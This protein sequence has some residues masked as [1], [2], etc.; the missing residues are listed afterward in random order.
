MTDDTAKSADPSRSLPATDSR[1]ELTHL[2][3]DAN[4]LARLGYRQE[5]QRRMSRFSNFAVSFSLICILAGGITAFPTAL[6]AGGG[7]S[8]AGGWLIGTIFAGLVALSMAQIASAYPT[9][10]GLYHWSSMLGNRGL[11]W[12]TAWFNLI[13]LVLAF[14]S[15]N[16]GLYDPFIKTLLVPLLGIDSFGWGLAH[17]MGWIVLMTLSQVLLNHYA[18]GLTT[19]FI[20]LSGYLILAVAIALVVLLW[21]HTEVPADLQRLVTLRN[22]TGAEGSLWPASSNLLMVFLSGLLLATYALTGFDASAHTAEETHD[23]ASTVPRGIIHSVLW[24]GVFGL[25]M[26]CTF[27]LVMPDLATGVSQGTG[28]FAALLNSIPFVPRACLVIGILLANFACGLSCLMSTS[29]MVYA[30]ARDGGLPWS[31][32]LKQ[33]DPVTRS[34][35]AAV[36]VCGVGAVA[37]TLYADAFAVLSTGCAVFLFLSYVM[38]IAAGMWAEGRHWQDK[39]PFDLGWMSRPIAL[40]GVLGGLALVWIG[41]QPP[42]EKVLVLV[43]GLVLCGLLALFWWGLGVRKRFRGPPLA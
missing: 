3:A 20:D 38:P 19:R 22:F 29:R 36:W 41:I 43:L 26:V 6:S 28:Y 24:S 2:D 5:L 37:M 39:G 17:Q 27:V 12:L 31:K 9:A 10:G 16:F 33:V 21:V 40:L 30:F 13:D 7:L 25:F 18:V 8:V 35:V 1:A 34:P 4:L 14:G 32:Q 15:I 11:G 23:A 42:N